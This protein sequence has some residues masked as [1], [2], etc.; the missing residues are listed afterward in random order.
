MSGIDTKSEQ[1]F[2]Q[3]RPRKKIVV[4]SNTA[5]FLYNFHLALLQGLKRGGYDVHLVAPHD[6]YFEKLEKAGLAC[7]ALS[8]NSK[9]VNPFEDLWLIGRF[10]LLYRRLTPDLILHFTIKPNIYGSLAAMF[11]RVPAISTITGLGT[12]FLNHGVSSR[13]G[14]LLYRV[15]LKVPRKVFFLNHAD[16][17]LFIK[18]RLVD[19]AKSE[20][21]GGAGIDTQRFVPRLKKR[22]DNTFRFLLIAR[23]IRDKGITEYVE[24]ARRVLDWASRSAMATPVEFCLLGAY[25][26][27]NPTALTPEEVAKWEAEGVLVYL[28]TTDEVPCV[29][30]DADCIVLPSYREGISQV[31]LEAASMAKP[32]VATDVPGCRE[33]VDDGINGYLCQARDVDS[34]AAMMQKMMSSSIAS[35]ETM[36]QKGRE[37][38]MAEFDERVVNAKYIR[39][40]EEMVG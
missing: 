25:Y 35:R 11:L 33:I 17:Q 9:G 10:Y 37:K 24:A 23:L 27:G 28:G 4:V 13:A 39:A 14:Q 34:L 16:R 15:A 5:W 21:I 30:A 31:L 1:S 6:V 2:G 18:A 22:R 3:S 20:V 38:I 19:P 36:G 40:I 7:H 26:S 29:I 12:I 8:I 32:I